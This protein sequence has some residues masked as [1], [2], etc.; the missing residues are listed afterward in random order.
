M[1]PADGRL[2]EANILQASEASLTGESLPIRKDTLKL[3]KS[4]ALLERKNMI[5]SGTVITSGKGK[6][7]VTTTGM[8]TE[9]GMI[10]ES[11]MT[12]EK[13]QTPLNSRQKN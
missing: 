5:F 9:F 4:I 12:L 10:A 7:V 3:A 2:I 13:T 6:A 1:D 11:V 8:N